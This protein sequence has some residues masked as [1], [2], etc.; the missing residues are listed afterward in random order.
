MANK[1]LE[2]TQTRGTFQFKGLVMGVSKD[3]F[4]KETTT[5]NSNKP[6]RNISFGVQV[7]KDSVVYISLNG[8][9]QDK[10]YFSK[11]VDGKTDTI[12]TEWNNRF[13]FSREGYRMIGVNCGLVKT[14]DEKGK[15]IN[16]KKYLTPYDAAEYIHDHLRDGMSVFIRGNI[17]YSHYATR[18]GTVTRATKFIP[19]QISLC[20]DVDFSAEDYEVVCSFTQPLV[21]MGIR[22]GEQENAGKFFVDAKII[23]YK[24]IEEAEFVITDEKLAK[25]F[26]NNLKPYTGIKT[27][28]EVIT[29][30][31]TDTVEADDDGWGS[32]N[33]MDRVVSPYKRLLVIT[34]A[35]PK[36]IDK[37]AY[38][39]DAIDKALEAMKS[40][41]KAKQEFGEDDW[42]STS[43]SK[44]G[45]DSLPW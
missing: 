10:V 11:T 13:K 20:Q 3:S 7:A 44:S 12:N 19:N 26:K 15:Q 33:P 4:Y 32:S 24:T 18:D 17:E 45:D 8:M 9:P 36:S 16:D 1:G 43:D 22:K 35:D 2:L 14:T 25:L 41:E 42:G 21:F 23:N 37:E 40:E 27:W 38:S 6:F 34:G 5:K 39:E 29:V 30:R 28:G 31:N